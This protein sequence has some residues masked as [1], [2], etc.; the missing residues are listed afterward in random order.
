MNGSATLGGLLDVLVSGTRPT[1]SASFQILASG[2]APTGTFTNAPTEYASS[3]G[4]F[5][6]NYSGT[7]VTLSGFS[8]P[9]DANEDGSVNFSDLLILAQNYNKTGTATWQQGDFTQDKAV[10]FPDL[11]VLAQHYGQ[12]NLTAPGLSEVPEPGAIGMIVLGALAAVRRRR[13]A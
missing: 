6:V 5:K 11:L 4:L 13:A 12:S 3:Q 7:G 9:G 2:G 8:L 1:H 10:G